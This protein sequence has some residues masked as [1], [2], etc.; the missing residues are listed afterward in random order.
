MI[1]YD[2]I[3]TG[4]GCAGMSLMYYLLDSPLKEK[5]ILLIDYST[6][7]KND[8]TWC[9]WAENPLS[10][11]PKNSPLVYWDNINIIKSDEKVQSRLDN[12]KYFHIKSSDFYRE[13]IEKIKK[14]PNV[15]FINDH[16]SGLKQLND[17]HVLVK[18]EM[19]G[20][21]TG[22]KV[23]NSIPFDIKNI[24]K[25]VLYQTFV[26]WR[27]NCKNSC[28]DKSAATLMHFPNPETKETEFFYILP[29]NESEA[30]IEYTLYTKNKVQIELLEKKLD[31]Y[32]K[33]KLEISEF[34]ILFRE[35]GSIPMTT[36]K[37][38]QPKESNII[39]IGT[40]AGCTKPSTG[41]TFYDIQ[42][43]SKQ[44]LNQL[45]QNGGEKKY[46]WNRKQR[47]SF[48]DNILLNI[49][50]KWP[51]ELPRIF[52]EMF[53]KNH[54]KM[55]LRFLNEESSFWEEVKILGSL[56]YGIFIKSLLHYEKH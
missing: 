18:T 9:Y 12:F 32:L 43:H 24:V 55:V 50:V 13:I 33:N 51:S 41:Y 6:K 7:S 20:S 28:F 14:F 27:I 23:F 49:A 29:F 5:K 35:F 34:E 45:L 26:G 42:K 17:A 48:Y 16:I 47:F 53:E 15:T 44:I 31:E 52:K 39:S 3:V 40:L 37:F 25:P 19:N 1:T 8:R 21:F 4:L 2:F 10:I 46:H 11:H 36:Q 22:K 30:L 54:G 56:K 38:E